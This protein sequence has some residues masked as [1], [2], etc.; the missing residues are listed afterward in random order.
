M[1]NF[2]TAHP[3]IFGRN[4]TLHILIFLRF[5]LALKRFCAATGVTTNARIQKKDRGGGGGSKLCTTAPE[6]ECLR[7]KKQHKKDQGAAKR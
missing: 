7:F 4:A 2:R 3:S 6:I 1:E 5:L